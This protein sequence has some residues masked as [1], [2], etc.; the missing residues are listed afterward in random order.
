MNDHNEI[1]SALLAYLQ[2]FHSSCAAVDRETDLLESGWMDS[3]VVLDL[4]C[5][6]ESRFAVV[7]AAREV[8]PENLRSVRCMA[9]YVAGKRKA[10]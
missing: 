9:H 1:E 2:D 5:F 3:I 7:V 4:V 10:A 8:S 6:L